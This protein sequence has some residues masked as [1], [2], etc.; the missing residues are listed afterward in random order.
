MLVFQ[1][2]AELPLE[3]SLVFTLIAILLQLGRK[4]E[5]VREEVH[6][7][8][9]ALVSTKNLLLILLPMFLLPYVVRMHKALG[10]YPLL[11][12]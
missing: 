2:R 3:K 8:G 5:G 11:N 9:E 7:C 4:K 10:L 12:V 6:S 1:A